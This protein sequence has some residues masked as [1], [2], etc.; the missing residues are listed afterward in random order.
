MCIVK[1]LLISLLINSFLSR[2]LVIKIDKL[3]QT[4]TF[5]SRKA[6]ETT[7]FDNNT[8]RGENIQTNNVNEDKESVK[9]KSRLVYTIYIGQR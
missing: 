5:F 8:E 3:G 7:S 1:L 6:L 4:I 9:L 2:S